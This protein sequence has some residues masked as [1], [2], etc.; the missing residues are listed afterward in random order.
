MDITLLWKVIGVAFVV[1]VATQI[2]SKAGRDE[3]VLLVTLAGVLTV[4]VMIISKAAELLTS[5]R[6][7]FGL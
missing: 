1:F 5:I 3:Q 2:L 4:L 6:N 7:L